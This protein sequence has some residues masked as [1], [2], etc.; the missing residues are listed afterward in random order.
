M[1]EEE[2]NISKWRLKRISQKPETQMGPMYERH[3]YI[4]YCDC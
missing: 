4:A 2:V 3:T 1:S